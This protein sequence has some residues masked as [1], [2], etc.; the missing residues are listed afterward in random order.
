MALSVK[1]IV[2]VRVTFTAEVTLLNLTPT[3]Q[4]RPGCKV[5]PVQVF[6]PTTALKNQV[7][8]VPPET[9]TLVIVTEAPPAA[10]VFVRV[11]VAVPV[12]TLPIGV[13]NVIGDGL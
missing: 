12:P 8:A 1:V 11:T 7:V 5:A 9:A 13:G 6:A 2:P 3:V 10:V 4:V